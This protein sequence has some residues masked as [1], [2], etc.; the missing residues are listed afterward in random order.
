[1]L[2]FAVNYQISFSDY[3]ILSE[4]CTSLY[5]V[6]CPHNCKG[7]HNPELQKR[8]YGNS[9]HGTITDW[10]QKMDML[11]EYNKSDNF[12]IVGGEP[13]APWNIVAIKELLVKNTQFNI[14]LYTG[15]EIEY[16]KDNGVT[17]FTYLKTG[18]YNETKRNIVDT[19]E[20]RSVFTLG[21]TNQRLWDHELNLIS[22]KG[23]F[24]GK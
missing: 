24:K 8:D 11:A 20:N 2:T 4:W 10:L 18:L 9:E 12:V 14:C 21:S 23:I 19:N 5:T 13:L 16:V 22:N 7:C 15:Y 1:M 3:P 6:G 17:G